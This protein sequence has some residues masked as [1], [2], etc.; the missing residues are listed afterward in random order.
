MAVGYGTCRPACWF[1]MLMTET[2][3]SA[4]RTWKGGVNQPSGAYG[5]SSSCSRKLCDGTTSGL[6]IRQE[7]THSRTAALA[8][9]SLR[10]SPRSPRRYALCCPHSSVQQAKS[11]QHHRQCAAGTRCS[12]GMSAH[13]IHDHA[14]TCNRKAAFNTQS[15]VN[16]V[17]EN[18]KMCA[19]GAG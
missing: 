5:V 7:E 14:G 11:P 15:T 4:C 17:N 1:L 9:R 13:H 19:K 10:S 12:L 6:R 3:S 18:A 16:F 8:T 2:N